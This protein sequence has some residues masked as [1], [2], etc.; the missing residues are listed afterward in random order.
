[1]AAYFVYYQ[2]SLLA[3]QVIQVLLPVDGS[4]GTV[5]L[6]ARRTFKVNHG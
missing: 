1:M 4:S 6:L 3:E 2:V 5:K